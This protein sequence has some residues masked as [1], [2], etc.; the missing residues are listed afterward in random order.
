MTYKWQS[1]RAVTKYRVSNSTPDLVECTV[2]HAKKITLR[3]M[4][5]NGVGL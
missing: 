4:P 5:M 1:F 3:K 2:R